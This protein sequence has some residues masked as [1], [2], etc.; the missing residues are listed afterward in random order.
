MNFCQGEYDAEA[1][2]EFTQRKTYQH[3]ETCTGAQ[4]WQLQ[5]TF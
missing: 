4:H 1:S 2:M 5:Q 3:L